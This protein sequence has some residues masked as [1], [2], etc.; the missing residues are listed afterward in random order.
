MG[1]PDLVACVSFCSIRCV[2]VM[3]LGGGARI[4]EISIT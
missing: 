3:K 4:H 2:L 1:N